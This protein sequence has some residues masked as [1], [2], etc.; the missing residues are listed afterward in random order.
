MS[1]R[2]GP[3]PRSPRGCMRPA[4]CGLVH[5][6]IVACWS[7]CQPTARQDVAS[8]RS[9]QSRSLLKDDSAA[10]TCIRRPSRP[11][12]PRRARCRLWMRGH[13]A[14]TKPCRPFAA[15]S[16]RRVQPC[17]VASFSDAPSIRI[18]LVV[19]GHRLGDLAGKESIGRPSTPPSEGSKHRSQR[20]DLERVPPA[21]EVT[22]V[23]LPVRSAP[24][25]EVFNSTPAPGTALFTYAKPVP[26]LP[27]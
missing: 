10:A 23:I 3:P 18:T 20:T 15:A 6:S 13:R 12:G 21:S 1:R 14:S 22:R 17:R 24:D 26:I 7:R 2:S 27:G 16:R 19:S 5:K 25:D 4:A 11:S 8:A 9:V